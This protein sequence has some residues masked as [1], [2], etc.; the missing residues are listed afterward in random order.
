MDRSAYRDL[1]LLVKV[2]N[3][4]NNNLGTMPVL[5]CPSYME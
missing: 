3:H 4:N 1:Y 5:Y 2:N